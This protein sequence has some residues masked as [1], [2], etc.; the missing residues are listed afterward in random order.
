M[1]ENSKI[2]WCDHTFNPWIGCTKVS[3]AC[4]NCYAETYT[5]RVGGP[6]W[7]KGKPRRRT[8]DANWRKPFAWNRKAEG[9]AVRPKVFCSSLA[10]VF[11]AEV[12][13]EWRKDLWSLIAMTPNLDWLLLTK[14]PENIARMLPGGWGDGWA[15]VWLG[16]TVE[17]QAQANRRVP[18]LLA[19][20]AAKHF[21]SCEPLLGSLDLG[22]VLEN[23]PPNYWFTWLDLLDWVIC[24]GES[25][26]GARP[27]DPDWVR[28]LRDQCRETDVPFLFKQWGEWHPD[29][30]RHTDLEGNCPPPKMRIGKAKTGRLLDGELW[31]QRP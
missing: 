11:D 22:R 13:A 19:A 16:T 6:E 1:G 30:L 17:N 8:T 23:L 12:P 18:V 21:L 20:D 7:G 4:V 29:A 5:R 31:D 9:A 14:R 15:N 27:I 3:P 28:S 2:E 25:G 26:P 24:G 10:D